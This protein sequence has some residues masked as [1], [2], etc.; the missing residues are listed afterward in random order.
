MLD[1]PNEQSSSHPQNNVLKNFVA[2]DIENEKKILKK[3]YRYLLKIL[4][5]R[6]NKNSENLLR[7]AFDMSV[8]AHS[9]TRRKSGELYIFH[10]IAVA[11][12]V[13]EEI[14]LGLTS[15][16]CGL[17]HDTVEDTEL[18]IEDIRRAFNNEIAD[19]IEGLTKISGLIE[20]SNS[21]IQIENFK[22]LILTISKDIRVILIKIADRLHNMRTMD[23]MRTDKQQ[24]IA[25]ETLFLYAPLANR[26]GLNNIKT[27]LEDLSLK[28]LEPKAYREIALKL[29]ETKR[30][31]NK[32]IANFIAPIQEDLQKRGIE[33]DMYGRPKSIYSIWNKIKN[34]SIPFEEVFDLLA[35]RIILDVPLEL[36]KMACWNVYS[37]IT[38]RYIPVVERMRDWISKP[39][40]NGYEA[41]HITVMSDS[42]KFI[43][44]QIRTK[45]MNEIAEKGIA[46]H[47]LYKEGNTKANPIDEWLKKIADKVKYGE[48][49]SAE[50]VNDFKMDLYNDEVY[51]FTPKG[52]LKTLPLGSTVLDFAYEIHSEV[53]NKCIGAKINHKLVPINYVLENGNQIEILT[54]QKQKP[55]EEW[56][57]QVKTSKARGAIKSALK[58]K[59]RILA[60][61]GKAILSKKLAAYNISYNDSNIVTLMDFYKYSDTL[62]F[63]SDIANHD[64][65]LTKIK[66]LQVISGILK[67]PKTIEETKEKESD[68][69][70]V[71]IKET[72]KHNSNLL[73]L[74][75]DSSKIIYD[76]AVCCTPIPGDDV[77]GFITIN[78]GVKIHRVNCPNAVNLMSKYNYRIVKTKWSSGTHLSFL[79][80]IVINGIDDMGLINTITN[81][82]SKEHN[83]NIRAISIESEDG[84][85]EGQIK[86]YVENSEQL[87]SIVANLLKVDGIIQVRRV[88]DDGTVS[89]LT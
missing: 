12:I 43:E 10:P 39:K 66:S 86:L 27:E 77:F 62:V 55:R 30:Q 8:A 19:I 68:E 25:S 51:V 32:Y 58:Q 4:K 23:S 40:S 35:V 34:K 81:I 82:I 46:A 22:K 78:D 17:M 79:T 29:K 67:L 44:V 52:E 57:Q 20:H 85:F 47:Y 89:S 88:E 36:E 45:R 9:T 59:I 31:R 33:F 26:I 60:Q 63:L 83:V 74:G 64:V 14:G 53:G 38:S 37:I 2:Y 1:T 72:L 49:T 5:P 50:L 24:K 13:V 76:F 16:I 65:D 18:T 84:I 73:I 42:G 61:D 75:E 71:K 11:K 80:G 6:L 56:L 7:R 21:S 41:L 69:V 28:Y 15:A 3:E 70:L 54:S 87:D 48:D